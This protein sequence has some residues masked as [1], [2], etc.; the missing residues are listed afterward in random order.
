[1]VA[2]ARRRPFKNIMPVIRFL[3]YRHAADRRDNKTMFSLKLFNS[4]QKTAL[5]KTPDYPHNR[6]A[7]I[8]K[9]FIEDTGTRV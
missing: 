3:S 2:A 6:Q 4:S 9:I 8:A 7:E 1:M 5:H